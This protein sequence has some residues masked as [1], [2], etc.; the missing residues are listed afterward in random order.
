MQHN[1]TNYVM[2]I[3]KFITPLFALFLSTAYTMTVISC[4]E[5][6][7]PE[8]IETKKDPHLNSSK[9]GFI[10]FDSINS[11]D[12]TSYICD[13][14]LTSMDSIVNPQSGTIV[15]VP[16]K[17]NELANKT[18]ACEI[19]YKSLLIR[20]RS[21]DSLLLPP[22]FE[23]DENGYQTVTILCTRSGFGDIVSETTHYDVIS[24]KKG[25]CQIKIGA[26]IC[27]SILGFKSWE[28]H[29]AVIKFDGSNT[30]KVINYSVSDLKSAPAPQEE[31]K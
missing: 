23:I 12:T 25:A 26:T 30:A 6:D 16:I 13:S 31:V 1:Q 29:A 3:K 21:F 14:I 4:S 18:Y 5:F 27:V 7:E 15:A 10:S 17:Y 28:G 8:Y 19:H 2:K 22:D 9:G 20:Y 24:R 11:I